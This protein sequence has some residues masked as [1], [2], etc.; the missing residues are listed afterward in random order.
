MPC[1]YKQIRNDNIR[2][3][4][5]GIRHLSFLGR[6]YT[7]RTHFIF[8]LLQNAEDA[9]AT[10]ILFHLFENRLEVF[11]DGRLFDEKDV[12]GICGVGEGTKAQDLT[13]IGKF[14]IGFKSVYAYTT[15]PEIHSGHESFRIENYVRPYALQLREIGGSWTTLFVF[16]FNKEDVEPEI[17]CK[18][19]SARL[20]KLSG[21]TLLFLRRIKEI[22]YRLPDGMDG[23]Y[24]RDEAIHG[25][26]REVT[27]IGQSNGEDESESW[28]IFERPLEVPDIGD[29][30]RGYVSVEVGFH[31]EKNE[32][33]RRDEV[34][35][36]KDSPLVVYFPT[37]KET[38]F[39]F[40][41]QGPY[42][43]T[44]ARD[45]IPKEDDWNAT[46]VE[47][48]ACLIADVLPDLKDL[49]LFGVSLLEAL[50]IRMDNFPPGS[51]FYPIVVAVRE[52][53][54]VKQLLPADDGSFVSARN[55]KLARGADLRKLLD[56]DQLTDLFQSEGTVK[57]LSGSITQDR[58]P[59]LRTYLLN[60]LDVEEITPDSFARKIT[61]SFLLKQI[62]EWLLKFYG[63]LSGQEALWRSPRWS[64][65]PGGLLRSKP[66]V[67]LQDDSQVTP[68]RADGTTPN[69]FLPPPEDTDFPIVKRSIAGDEQA[70]NFMSRLGLSEPDVFDDIVERVLPKYLNSD[71]SS[72]S[73]HEHS[74]DIQKI[75]RAMASDSES[76]KKKAIESAKKTPFLKAVNQSREIAFKKPGDI[77]LQTN[78][79]RIYFGENH[80]IC[81]LAET[82][83]VPEWLELGVS[84]KPR[85]GKMQVDLPHDERRR[86]RRNQGHTRDIETT[87]YDLDGLDDF[88]SQFPEDNQQFKQYSLIIWNFLLQ[89]LK[90]KSYYS[91]YEGE[92]RWFYY[93]ERS[94]S[95]DATWKK[96]LRSYKWIPKNGSITPHRP[97]QLSL[98]DLPEQ[99]E[100]NERL[101]DL[102]GMKKDFVT[103]L[104]EQA[105]I[106]TEDIDLLKRYP[107]EF[108]QW[109]AQ[110]V[111][112]EEKPVF[113]KRTVT[114]PERRQER[115]TEQ[116]DGS[117]KKEYEDRERSVR[118][119]KG[120]ID[121]SLWLREQY[122]N[123]DGQMVC[124]ICK[125]E[126]P[127]RKRNDEHYF[128][129]VEAFFQDHFPME[130]E[131]QFLA[132]C[133]LCA[134]MYKELVKKDEPAMTDL[135]KA[136]LNMDSL[137]APLSLGDLETSI[138][139]VETHFQDIRTILEEQE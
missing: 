54:V 57:W 86:L 130:H 71:N 30:R 11:H 58:T 38:R 82:E 74:A 85:F 105:G 29:D 91:F 129:A 139:F 75:L 42:K 124:Q 110:M 35:R 113:P 52:A 78:E 66:I 128:E 135:R 67:R 121:P 119:T 60:E 125:K 13:Q 68:F 94:A 92:Y 33:E 46:L 10:R 126:M 101:A 15:T 117:P 137:E 43:T 104:A 132:L 88:L 90:E 3:Y 26:A 32:K 111:A 116:L 84:R 36:V 47:E 21:R 55:A 7:D 41:I 127:F 44:P 64:E 69:A 100:R 17:A 70:G 53:L 62:D 56:Y 34:S 118:A 131:A 134:A 59:E 40:L 72:I 107:E 73:Q 12:R 19:I 45:N 80:G 5:E 6:L 103:E 83:G 136:L 50:P 97:E 89:H 37:E 112:P 51:M 138:E 49:G 61:Q 122:T 106:P 48:T 27:V 9:R 87:D 63:Y 76:G 109:K 77:Y 133:P 31:L 79:L 28:L 18:E 96:R 2:E 22:V 65:D 120:A 108:K 1:N 102:I 14:G 8:E 23:V 16:P 20:H 25:A 81:Y 93:Q 99:F 115:L 24:L 98:S 95:F 39:G 123:E 114:N 4:G